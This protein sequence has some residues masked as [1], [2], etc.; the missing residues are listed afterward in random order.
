MQGLGV[1]VPELGRDPYCN[2]R[3]EP[4][5]VGE[6]LAEMGQVS[7]VQLVL[8]GD[9]YVPI[10]LFRLDIEVVRAYRR[11]RLDQ[12]QPHVKRLA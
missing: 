3:V 4:G 11:F 12:L 8:D 9:L 7:P 5:S 10:D 6:Q 1:L 2:S